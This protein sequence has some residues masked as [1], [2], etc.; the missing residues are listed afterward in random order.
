MMKS[1]RLGK[2]GW[3][4]SE[5]GFGAWAIGGDWGDVTED[6]ALRSLHEALDRGVTFLDTAD[7][8]GGGRSEEL[9]GRVLRE[10]GGEVIVAT[11][12]GR[13]PGWSD[14]ARAV[15]DAAAA[16]LRR[17][18]VEAL[19]LV[20]LH[21]VPFG[22]LKAGRAIEH[23][24]RL[25]ER[26]WIRA[27]G[28]SVETIEEARHCLRHTGVVSL[29]VIFNLFR[30]RL[31]TELFPE[32]AE[33]DVAVIARVP[34]ASGL[35]TGK[36][37]PGHRFAENDHRSF[38]ANGE[39][40]HVGETFAGLPFDKGVLLAREAQAILGAD[41]PA[42]MAR[43]ALRWILDHEA[44]STVIPGGKSPAQVAV[45]CSASSAPPLSG[46]IHAAL[47]GHYASRVEPEIRGPY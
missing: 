9:I 13:G 30:Q 38:N 32:A 36:F 46:T 21:C 43:L 3:S 42:D 19:D 34:L 27:Y 12:M 7:V 29:Q 11:K 40:F 2:T 25:K 14:S 8:Y 16:S 26:G 33:A 31:V 39:R 20:Q 17:L 10:R 1:R 35:L 37:D 24:E 28:A 4:V 44:V 22:V 47:R 15:E 5:V 41:Q 45:N 6:E 23:L 18:G